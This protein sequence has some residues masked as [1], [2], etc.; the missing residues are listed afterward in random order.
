MQVYVDKYQFLQLGRSGYKFSKA[1]ANQPAFT[2]TSAGILET[3]QTDL[4]TG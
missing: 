3:Y 2:V 1:R 4:E